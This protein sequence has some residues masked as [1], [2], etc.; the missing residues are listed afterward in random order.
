[1]TKKFFVSFYHEPDVLFIL[2]T[3]S[4]TQ[5]SIHYTYSYVQLYH[6]TYI[7]LEDTDTAVK[8]MNCTLQGWQFSLNNSRTQ[9]VV[10]CVSHSVE[11]EPQNYPLSL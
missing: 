8:Y 5:L 6:I 2:E 1:M 4:L 7:A 10:L 3:K 11:I 9:P